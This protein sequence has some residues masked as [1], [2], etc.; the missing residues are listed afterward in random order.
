[1]D[2]ESPDLAKLFHTMS[3]SE[4]LRR[5]GAGSLTDIART[6]AC[7][8]LVAR[9]LPLPVTVDAQI[10]P[11]PYEGDFETVAQ[12]LNPIDAHLIAGCLEASGIPTV[13]ADNHLVQ[14]HSLLT[15]AVGGVRIRV[16]AAR[17]DE[18]R[19]IIAAFHRGELALPDDDKSYLE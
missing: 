15:I 16:A 11:L 14:M 17:A 19:S 12:L 10:A 9:G 3:D 13:I 7:A 8:E 2:I 6:V 4:L 5:C 1:M 18:A